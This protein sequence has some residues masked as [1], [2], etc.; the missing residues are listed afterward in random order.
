VRTAVRLSGR[1]E[2]RQD[3][4][5]RRAAAVAEQP[6]VPRGPRRD[7]PGRRGRLG[8]LH[9]AVLWR[10]FAAAGW[11]SAPRRRA[12]PR[13]RRSRPSTWR[14][15]CCTTPRPSAIR[16]RAATA[17]TS[18]SPARPSASARRR[19]TKTRSR[20]AP[21][22]ACSRRRGPESWPSSRPR[23]GRTWRP[24]RR[25]RARRRS[26]SSRSRRQPAR[27]RLRSASRCRRTATASA[28]RCGSRSGASR[29]PT[30]MSVA[31]SA[32]A[33]STVDFA[34]SGPVRDLRS[35]SLE[36][37]HTWVGD[38][39]MTL[40][41]PAGKPVTL[42]NRPGADAANLDGAKGDDFRDLVLP[43]AQRPRSTPSR[44]TRRW[45]AT[46]GATSRPKHCR[47]LT[48]TARELGPCVCATS[49]RAWPPGRCARGRCVPPP[50]PRPDASNTAAR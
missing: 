11:A 24:A 9:Y 20:S 42:M 26:A 16:R 44:E 22:A 43:T 25:R 34:E 36:R 1:V 39:V 31:T 8:G 47:R 3:A 37:E 15:C 14:R 45:A 13:R 12:P 6:V 21:S 49:S 28:F 27:A 38:L 33:S 35:A 29:A 2:R 50:A 48:A 32:A 7:H 5:H 41:N 19:A 46:R 40:T 4:R 18:P 17:T 10:L 23:R 30:C